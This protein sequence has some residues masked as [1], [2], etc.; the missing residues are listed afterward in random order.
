VPLHSCCRAGRSSPKTS[1]RA[2]VRTT[3]Q[4]KLVRHG[5]LGDSLNWLVSRPMALMCTGQCACWSNSHRSSRPCQ[6]IG[7]TRQDLE[8]IVQ[9]Q[10][11]TSSCDGCTW[12]ATILDRPVEDEPDHLLASDQV[13]VLARPGCLLS[14]RVSGPPL[15]RSVSSIHR[16]CEALEVIFEQMCV[17]MKSDLRRRMPQHSLDCFHGCSS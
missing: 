17:P 6:G 13:G 11:S 3:A 9:R 10:L 12:C 1:H 15:G 14:R 4:P 2:I 7:F 8:M 16:F 5:F